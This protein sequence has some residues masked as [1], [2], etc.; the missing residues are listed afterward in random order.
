M[1][2]QEK[3]SISK[4][5]STREV[6][7]EQESNMEKS[8]CD[9]SVNTNL[10]KNLKSGPKST[11]AEGLPSSTDKEDHDSKSSVPVNPVPSLGDAEK[12]QTKRDY[13]E[14]LDEKKPS[15]DEIEIS[16][17]KKKGNIKGGGDKQPTLLSYFGKK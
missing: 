2:T 4:F 12:S 7:K 1:K 5:F 15:K 16:P 9:E 11:D 6:K 17:A 8:L 10:L 3:N 14:F 13:E